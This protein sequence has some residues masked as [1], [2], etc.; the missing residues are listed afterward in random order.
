MKLAFFV[1]GLTELV[2]IKNLA[3]YYYGE[4]NLT[5]VLYQIRGGNKIP[6]SVS[7]E[8]KHIAKNGIPKITF[9]IYDCG[10]LT[11]I[12]SMISHQRDSLHNNGFSKIIGIRD[13]HPESADKIPKLIM[14]LPLRIP[15]KPIP[16]KFLLCIMETEAW[17]LA[18][19]NH[20]LKI[21]DKLT[22][23]FI[24]TSIGIDLNT[25]NI[26]S[27]P[28]PSDTLNHIYSIAGKSYKKNRKSI[29][30]TLNALDIYE[31]FEVLPN[32]YPDLKALITEIENNKK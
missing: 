9:F 15:Q 17:F 28:T 26:S 6:V 18:E 8:E 30:R 7:I 32:K 10:S 31:I 4:D 20:F 27:L 11:T 24:K 14:D 2:L 16:T 23:E 3:L 5:Y 19:Q 21:S 25:I 13:V 12:R 29:T 1:E 22:L